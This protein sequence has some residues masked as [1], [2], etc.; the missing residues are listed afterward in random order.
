MVIT[1]RNCSPCPRNLPL[2]PVRLLGV[3]IRSTANHASQ[4]LARSIL[5]PRHYRRP[6]QLHGIW[7]LHMVPYR[8]AARDPTL[9]HSIYRRRAHTS[10]DILSGWRIP[11]SMACATASGAMDSRDWCNC[12]NGSRSTCGNDARTT[13][14]LDP[15]VPGDSS[16]KFLSRFHLY[17]SADRGL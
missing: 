1:L 7:Q 8:M 5:W 16:A 17:G 14:L 2:C 9:D 13:N 12:C 11:G 15:D 6:V 10:C 4:S 3:Q